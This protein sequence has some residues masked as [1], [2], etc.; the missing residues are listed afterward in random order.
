M[1][2]PRRPSLLRRPAPRPTPS[3]SR[4][5]RRGRDH[6]QFPAAR[7]RPRREEPAVPITGASAFP[8]ILAATAATSWTSSS[9]TRH[10]ARSSARPE[11]LADHLADLPAGVLGCSDASQPP[12][13]PAYR[14]SQ[15]PS[16]RRRRVLVGG[17]W[18]AGEPSARRGAVHLA[19]RRVPGLVTAIQAVD[20][21]PRYHVDIETDDVHRDHQARRPGGRRAPPVVDCRILRASGGDSV[22]HPRLQHP[23]TFLARTFD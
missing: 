3:D 10:H 13:H 20:D 12:F 2:R 4:S 9:V 17:A 15:R 8:R 7:V 6:R 19:A 23:D 5:C 1:R 11:R 21:G 16:G 14:R 18:R 22:R